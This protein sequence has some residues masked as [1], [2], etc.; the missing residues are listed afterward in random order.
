[1]MR[2]ECSNI[3]QWQE[4]NRIG[5]ERAPRVNEHPYSLC[6]HMNRALI[7]SNNTEYDKDDMKIYVRK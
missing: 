1:M 5:K 3:F 6:A 7:K 2:T 4:G